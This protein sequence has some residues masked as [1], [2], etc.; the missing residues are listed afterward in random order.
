MP[1]LP[2]PLG[3][4]WDWQRFAACRGMDSSVFFS[5]AGERGHLRREREQRAQQVCLGCPVR[6]RCAEF[7]LKTGEAY[8]VWGGLSEAV[9]RNH[10]EERANSSV[11]ARDWEVHGSRGRKDPA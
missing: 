1:N 3:Q 11:P 4:F 2:T 10:F 5:P 7:A 9:R 8:G 6:R